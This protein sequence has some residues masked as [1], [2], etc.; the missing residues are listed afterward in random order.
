MAAKRERTQSSKKLLG[1]ENSETRTALMDAGERLMRD[2]GYAAV[3]SRRIAAVAGLKHQVIYYYFD[4]LDDLLL[5]VFRRSA[6]AGQARLREALKQEQPLRAIWEM[7]RDPRGNH[8]IREFTALA[9]RNEVIRAEIARYALETRRTQAEAIERH[10]QARGVEP[11]ISPTLISF[12]LAAVGR[13]LVNEES[14][15]VDE[16]HDEA[17]ALVETVLRRF[18]SAEPGQPTDRIFEAP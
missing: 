9:N 10:L 13:L 7:N 16:V 2:E 6:E 12:L 18:E 8:F 14:F 17:N 1:A 11:H 4:T 15:G 5:A 3:S